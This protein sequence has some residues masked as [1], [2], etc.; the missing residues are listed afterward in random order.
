MCGLKAAQ[1]HG[2]PFR[3]TKEHM[4]PLAAQ[5]SF[6]PNGK[7]FWFLTGLSSLLQGRNINTYA[8]IAQRYLNYMCFIS[9]SRNWEWTFYIHKDSKFLMQAPHRISMLLEHIW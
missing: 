5:D 2:R 6:L 1:I 3:A 4:Q 8:H 7:K 9:N